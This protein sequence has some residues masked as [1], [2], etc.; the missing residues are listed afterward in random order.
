MQSL[1]INMDYLDLK[2]ALA[3]ASSNEEWQRCC[4]LVSLLASC[5]PWPVEEQQVW[6]RKL[7]TYQ[8]LA[9]MDG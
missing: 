3:D 7:A 4:H 5:R 6:A 2:M 1:G 9:A 8:L